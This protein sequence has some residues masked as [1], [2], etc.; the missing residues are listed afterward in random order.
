MKAI[1]EDDSAQYSSIVGAH[2]NLTPF[3]KVN[4]KLVVTVKTKYV[5]EL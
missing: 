1:E 2:V 4:N 3:D 5:P